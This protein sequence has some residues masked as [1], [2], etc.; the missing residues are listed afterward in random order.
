[1]NPIAITLLLVVGWGVFAYSSLRRWRLMMVGAKENRADQPSER[2]RRTIKYGIAQLRMQRYPLAGFA[3]MLIFSGFTVLL[4]RTLILWGRGYDESFNFWFFGPQQTLGHIYSFLKDLF[5]VLVIFGALVFVYFR[6][7]KR[8]GRMTLSTEGL[9]ILGIIVVMMF[10]DIFYDGASIALAARTPPPITRV[11]RPKFNPLESSL[12][13]IAAKISPEKPHP[14]ETNGPLMVTP[15]RFPGEPN[16]R[17]VITMRDVTDERGNVIGQV[18]VSTYRELSPD[19]LAALEPGPVAFTWHEPAGSLAAQ[20]V[21]GLS[22]DALVTLKHL[23]FWTHSALVLIFL[24]LLPYSKHFHVITGIPN[25]Y[26]Q[27][28]DPPG[29]LPNLDDIEGKLEREE[30][31]RIKRI[32]QTSLKSVMDVY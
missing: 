22:D 30:T 12:T 2:I 15:R 16:K 25:V 17:E 31:L 4:L 19:E 7:F 28:L 11:A 8:L 32:D 3:H 5:A 1:M 26:F 27:R 14:S 13:E 21:E 24:N 9:V 6:V 18:P 23:G 29:K 20:V 10:A